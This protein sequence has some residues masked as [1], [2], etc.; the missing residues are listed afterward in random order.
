MSHFGKTSGHFFWGLPSSKLTR[1]WKLRH[2]MDDFAMKSAMKS[3]ILQLATITPQASP[4][5]TD[6]VGPRAQARQTSQR[7]S[8][9]GAWLK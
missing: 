5:F 1:L 2:F 7:R 3:W 6:F 8:I 4:G 9:T